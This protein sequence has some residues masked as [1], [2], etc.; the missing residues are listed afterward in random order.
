[1]IQLKKLKKFI[2]RYSS[3]IKIS[4]EEIEEIYNLV[5]RANINSTRERKKHV[6]RIRK[7][8]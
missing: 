5:K 2:K 3:D 4:K 7:T 1:M 8:Y 6:K